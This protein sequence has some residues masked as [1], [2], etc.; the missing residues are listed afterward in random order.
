MVAN[1]TSDQLQYVYPADNPRSKNWLNVAFSRAGNTV[2][3]VLSKPL[4]EFKGPIGEA[5]KYFQSVVTAG[6]GKISTVT[7]SDILLAAESLLPQYFFATKFYKKHADK[8]HLMKQFSL[9]DLVRAIAPKYRHPGY[10][11]DFLISLG[12]ERIIITF[13]EF[14]E[15]FL[16]TDSKSA[17]VYMTPDDIYYQK[18]LEGY[19]YK[20]I[21][22][23]AFNLGA[24][25]VD[26]LDALLT[27]AL[28]KS[29]WPR[30][31]GFLSM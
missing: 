20:I 29:N 5:M 9:G 31:N 17:S 16:A 30:D 26:T 22:L 19:G 15:Q 23:N 25:P 28:R 10:K 11:V 2:H 8:V 3:F 12:D 18:L 14:K 21:R 4:E 27:S 13:D 1:E 6:G 24:K 7:T